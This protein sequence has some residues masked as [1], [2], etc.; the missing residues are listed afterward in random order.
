MKE[1]TEECPLAN[2][3]LTSVV[4]L[5]HQNSLQ[6]TDRLVLDRLSINLTYLVAHVKRRLAMD[7]SPVH[8]PG[9]NAPTVLGHLQGDTHR[10]VG[11]LLELHQSHARHVL[12]LSVVHSIDVV[13]TAVQ[14]GGDRG[15][16]HPQC[17]IAVHLS[18][19]YIVSMQKSLQGWR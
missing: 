14:V 8:D 7:H 10:L 5:T 16:R 18:C 9:H 2:Q 13:H 3:L 19:N 15:W 11:V 12:Q 1:D 17:L 4:H 6:L